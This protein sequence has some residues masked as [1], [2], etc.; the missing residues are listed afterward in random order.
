MTRIEPR[1]LSYRYLGER[2]M[3]A[4]SEMTSC[5]MGASRNSQIA[6]IELSI[7]QY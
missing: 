2:H 1:W 7:S 6:G 5:S 3:R 4:V